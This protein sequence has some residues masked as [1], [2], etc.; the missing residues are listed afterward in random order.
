MIVAHLK[1]L[2][3]YMSEIS[4]WML[5][6]DPVARVQPQSEVEEYIHLWVYR[7]VLVGM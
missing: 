3:G 1:T 6:V 4:L 5:F 7:S 2:F